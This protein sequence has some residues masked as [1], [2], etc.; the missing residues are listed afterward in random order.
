MILEKDLK[1]QKS[2]KKLKTENG[3]AVPVPVVP[4]IPVPI[5]MSNGKAIDSSTS[6]ED[7]LRLKDLTLSVGPDEVFSCVI[8][9]PRIKD[10]TLTTQPMAG[11]TVYADAISADAKTIIY[12]WF[13][14]S[15][16]E[17]DQNEPTD[18]ELL[19]AGVERCCTKKNVKKPE[20]FKFLAL[21]DRPKLKID[22]SCVGQ[23]ICCI[24]TP[25]NEE[26]TN[27][28]TISLAATAKQPVST[29]PGKCPYHKR[30]ETEIFDMKET[31]IHLFFLLIVYFV[32]FG[33]FS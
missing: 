2:S 30:H 12:K 20:N 19:Q 8:N 6:I 16:Q 13:V 24:A 29:G 5:L 31:V 10:L 17:F 9:P 23:I 32:S 4:D 7:A 21:T 3:E 14:G 18:L 1:R 33:H 25:I 11:Y 15:N 28:P 27:I 26:R 22:K